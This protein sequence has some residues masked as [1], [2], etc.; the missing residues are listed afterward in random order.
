MEGEKTRA[1][2]GAYA[3]LILANIA[4]GEYTPFCLMA[5]AVFFMFRYFY[6]EFKQT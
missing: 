5:L 6:L 1:F 4:E 3:N 2:I